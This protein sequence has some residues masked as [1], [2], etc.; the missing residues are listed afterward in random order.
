[1]DVLQEVLG[2]FSDVSSWISSAVTSLLPMF[3]T[4]EGGLTLIG[5]LAVAGLSI[6]VTFLLIGV[7]TNFLQFRA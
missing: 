6:S 3:Y 4:A 1:M 5:V 2:V 7:I